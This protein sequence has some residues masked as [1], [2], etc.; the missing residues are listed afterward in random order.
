MAYSEPEKIQARE[1]VLTNAVRILTVDRASAPLTR[2]SY[3]REVREHLI[4]NGLPKDRRNAEVLLIESVARWEQFFDSIVQTRVPAE[5]KVA[6]LSGPNPENDL[7]VLCKA[8]VLPENIWAFESDASTY[9]TAVQSSLASEFPFIK[10]V[11][12]G[13]DAFLSVS[14]QKFDIIYLD[15]C[16]PLPNRDKKQKTLLAV[17]RLL[18]GHALNSP[19]V[20]V[21]NA[22]LPKANGDSTGHS[23]LSRLVAGY[24]Y[25]KEFLEERGNAGGFIEGAQA[26]GYDFEA[27]LLEVEKNLDDYYG[28]YL[29]RLLMDHA[30][31]IAPATRV[32]LGQ[33]VFT[34]L[35]DTTDDARMKNAISR[36]FHFNEA[37]L[38]EVDNEVNSSGAASCAGQD[39]PAVSFEDEFGGDVISEAGDYPLLWTLAAL[40]AGLRKGDEN[41]PN[42]GEDPDFR[43]FADVFISQLSVANSKD[44][45][46]K[47]LSAVTYLLSEGTGSEMFHAPSLARL[48]NG[49]EIRDFYQF[50]DL[51][52]FHQLKELLL[53]QWTVPYHVNVAETM[54]WKYQ[55]KDT[56]M[57]MDLLVLDECRYVYDW[58]PTADMLLSGVHDPQRQLSFR[59]A[60][61]GVSKHGRW[62]NSEYFRGT[63]VIDQG[64][65]PFE[66]KELA[67]RV[68]I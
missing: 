28:Q 42:L 59:F 58:M 23:L 32:T 50:C 62:Y 25:P 55:A 67:H 35:F 3:V 56:P 4:A 60:L 12:G 34:R 40:D 57:Y 45:T 39:S 65:V 66:A 11:E 27:W 51:V 49:H 10:L 18:A 15:F 1:K 29:T 16:G 17:T 63:A 30:S 44:A 47:N 9:T 22:A 37:T 7:R 43:K 6:Y 26:N 33:G 13:I 52:L 8:G 2:R 5:L 61:D 14:P 54:R 31:V 19:G 21:T 38:E 64:T 46:I 68:K 36:F 41:Y 48:S 20:L 24:L 53:R